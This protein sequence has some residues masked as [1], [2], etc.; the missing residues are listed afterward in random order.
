MNDMKN[1]IAR[2]EIVQAAL[3][4]FQKRLVKE[5]MPW[6]DEACKLRAGLED[7]ISQRT[8]TLAQLLGTKSKRACRWTKLTYPY[9]PNYQD[10]KFENLMGW[11]A[12]LERTT[13]RAITFSGS[14]VSFDVIKA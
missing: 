4:E 7:A 11:D 14:A 13:R 5:V 1:L 3:E 9:G 12:S 10:P 8:Q 6:E 2:S